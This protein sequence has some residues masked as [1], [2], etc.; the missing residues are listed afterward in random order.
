MNSYKTG[1]LVLL[2]LATAGAAGCR[3]RSAQREIEDEKLA[4]AYADLSAVSR[5][6]SLRSQ[7]VLDSL[8]ITKEEY[9]HAV[10]AA[11]RDPERW[12]EILTAATKRLENRVQ[13]EERLKYDKSSRPP[14]VRMP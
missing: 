1:S 11:T 8:G 14:E 9:L 7:T 13:R 10:E 6:D 5:L 3:D 4:V 2:L 12:Q